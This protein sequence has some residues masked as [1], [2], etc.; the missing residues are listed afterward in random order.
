MTE[1][2]RY[3]PDP[4]A[5]TSEA[6]APGR[7]HAIASRF[8][9]PRPLE[10]FEFSGKGNI[11]QHSYRVVSGP[12]ENRSHHL[13]QLLN[14]GVFRHPA[15]VI[16]AMG[17]CLEAQ[18]RALARLGDP[19][20]GEWE[21]L[22]LV[23]TADGRPFLEIP[24]E[25]GPRCWRMMGYI[26]DALCYRSLGEIPDRESRLRVAEEA[27]RGL[28]LFGRLTA[29]LDPDLL[30]APLPGY[31]NTALYYAQ[32]HSVLTGNRTAAD[33]APFLPE[34]A[35]LAADTQNDFIVHIPPGEFERR[36]ADAGIR[37]LSA[38]AVEHQ[39]FA[40]TLG[41]GLAAGR[42]KRTAVHGD[43][44]LENFLF[45][46]ATG[47][48]RA[49]VDLDTIMPHTWLSD[50]GD[51]VRSLVNVAGERETDPEK[52][53][54]DTGVYR[55]AARGFIL[56]AGPRAAGE[57]ALMAAAPA[58]MAL[59]LGVR[60]LADYVRGDRYFRLRPTDPPDLNRSRALVQFRVFEELRRNAGHLR[61]D[62][63]A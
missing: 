34:D 62:T 21:V 28:A 44:K 58:I 32:L 50:W 56:Q 25:D 11:N 4:R 8:A 18:R 6:R 48:V 37:R 30:R 22:N 51:M 38:L 23:P 33:A 31:R 53:R 36:R 59:E 35:D 5:G 57:T 27:G 60:F 24:G 42:L 16:E 61:A 41:R 14:P 39:E 3:P 54:I 15:G 40:L 46:T 1:P 52:I 7:I 17:L 19:D 2:S 9:L 29:D 43:T 26:R 55:A 13:L 12:P 45:S 20:L 49:L 47:R 63:G 10:V